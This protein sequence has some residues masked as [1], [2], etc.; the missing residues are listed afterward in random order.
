MKLT[1][2][3]RKGGDTLSELA[4]CIE[5][6]GGP[7]SREPSRLDGTKSAVDGAAGSLPRTAEIGAGPPL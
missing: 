1:E 2:H 5:G 4:T 7:L 3:E 6:S